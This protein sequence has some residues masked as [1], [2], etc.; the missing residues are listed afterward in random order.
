VHLAAANWYG[1]ESVDFVAG[2][3]QAASLGDIVAQVRRLG[4]NTVRLQWPNE[5][6]E[7][8]PIVPDYAVAAN[9]GLRGRHALDVFDRVVH[10][11]T[12]QRI[13]VILDNHNSTAE[14][15]CGKD[16]NELWYNKAYPESSWIADWKAMAARYADNPG[17]VGADLRNEP[18]EI[19]TWGG[20]DATNWQAAAERGGNAVLSVNPHLLIVVE[21]VSYAGDLS[22]VN[23]LPVTLDIPHRLVYS[24]HDYAWYEH[25]FNGYHQWYDQVYPKWGYLVGGPHP[26]PMWV[27]EYGTC[28]TSPKCVSSAA[29]GDNGFWFNILSTFLQNYR[30]SWAYW[31]LNGTQSTGSGRT[32]NA[33]DSYGLLNTQW[34]RPA[35]PALIQRLQEIM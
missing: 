30:V 8:N 34:D 27:S 32:W 11:L 10:T 23:D 20:P 29:P 17:V 28:N 3:L 31:P 26:Q 33:A 14:W 18:R 19:A 7:K 4:F 9:P 35:S 13:M 24:A 16:G 2:G 12:A 22:G 1:A 6:V 15:C 21:G 5:L 25:N